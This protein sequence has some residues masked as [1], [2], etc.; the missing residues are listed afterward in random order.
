MVSFQEAALII[1]LLLLPF[2]LLAVHGQSSACAAHD[3]ALVA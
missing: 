2:L 1:W 3:S